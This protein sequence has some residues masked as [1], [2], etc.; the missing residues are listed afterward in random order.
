MA[1]F[2]NLVGIPANPLMVE[3]I[4]RGTLTTSNGTVKP[5]LNVY[6]FRKTAGSSPTN[7]TNVVAA[8][9]AAL[10][11]PFTNTL[12]ARYTLTQWECRP[13]D[14][15]ASATAIQPD[16]TQGQITTSDSYDSCS[17]VSML[18][19]T[20]FRGRSFKGAKRFGPLSEGDTTNDQLVGTGLTNWT[21]LRDALRSIM[22]GIV[23]SDSNTWT[24][25]VLSTTLST[26]D[27]LPAV[28]TGADWADVLLNKTIG[29]MRH[30]KEKTAR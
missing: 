22:T 12:N 27:S 7:S 10:V 21:A 24:P 23:D 9:A 26:L 4:S 1:L 6:H 20:G 17:C 18:I 25:V 28:F 3:V 30:R 5:I 14:D 16:G 2:R 19:R 8:V 29:T 13:L 11:G 15:P